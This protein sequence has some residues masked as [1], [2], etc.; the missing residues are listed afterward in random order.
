MRTSFRGLPGPRE[1]LA[2]AFAAT[3]ASGVTACGDDKDCSS[4]ADC[5]QGRICRV[6]LCALDPN[7][8]DGVVDGE[9][10]SDVPLDCQPAVVGD[11]VLNEIMADPPAGADID[12][13]SI[14]SAT[15]D[16]FVE[17]VNVSA[18]EVALSN[19]EIDVGGK[20]VAAG[21]LCLAPNA[22]RVIFGSGGL[23]SLTNSG[24]AVSLVIDGGVA[25]THA[26]GS[27]GGKDS[28]L[29]LATQLDPTAAWVLHKDVWG[30]P[31]SAG[32]CS[33]GNDFPDCAGGVVQPD[34]EVVDGETTGEIIIPDCE[35]AP[36]ADDLVINEVM[37]DPGTGVT[38]LDA[39][40]DGVVDSGDDEFVE[41]VNVSNATLLLEGVT[42]SDGGTNSFSFGAV[43]VAPNQAIVVFGNYQGTGSFP[44]VLA[45]SGGGLSLNNGGDSVV[46]RDG[47][48]VLTQ[49]TYGSEADADQSIVR[50]TDLDANAAF[51]KHSLAPNAGGS[52]MS[53]GRC[54][55]GNAFP[56]C[57]GAAE[58]EVVESVEPDV[59]EAEVSEVVESVEETA[60]EV[61]DVS[62]VSEVSDVGETVE[63]VG[64]S[65]GP[66]P[67]AGDIVINEVLFDPP[68]GFDSNGDGTAETV[69]DEFV[70]IVNTS[71]GALILTG[72]K[73]G[74]AE[75]AARFTFGTVCLGQGEAV[76][77]FGKLAQQFTVAGVI[78][79]DDKLHSLNLNNNGPET[80]RLTSASGD[81]LAS[82]VFA[83]IPADQSTTRSP[84]VTG[85]FANHKDV[86]GG[87]PA[88]PGKCLGGVAFPGCL[89][90]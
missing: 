41:I 49:V 77:V 68:V 78:A 71:G 84:D 86:A 28:S 81:L 36:I 53:P 4:N 59:I 61:L 43:C 35:Q 18:R 55:N 40:G 70:E 23:P 25:Q 83:T 89:T 29:T 64:P 12:G 14:P 38:G 34:V 69:Q 13:N 6:G 88:S 15:E 30:A 87:T 1:I 7:V 10:A 65:C 54:Q 27:E 60:S 44:G 58:V 79:I 22:A 9:T 82:E 52:K 51:V 76:V 48:G 63:D 39:N 73:L 33:N 11:L 67:V 57:A 72:V 2:F 24:G 85:A 66:A 31:Y 37:A 3:V 42:L 20:R 62:E 16:E 90:P 46:L 47:A 19:V 56:D 74:D 75:N 50:T 80:V 32:K 26:Y 45:L 8:G 21:H 5:P 17:I